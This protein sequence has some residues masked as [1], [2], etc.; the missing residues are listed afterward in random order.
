MSERLTPEEVARLDPFGVRKISA[1]EKLKELLIES[2]T[3]EPEIII[4]EKNEWRRVLGISIEVQP[5]PPFVTKEV[6]RNLK[7]FGLELRFIP[8]L[9]LNPL[10]LKKKGVS[11]FLQELTRRYPNWRPYESLGDKEKSD[12]TVV[13]NLR[14]WHWEAMGNG[15]MDFPNLPGFWVAVE[16]LEKPAS[17]KKYPH[18]LLTDRLGFSDRFNVS[19]KDVTE[20]IDRK[21]QSILAE[22]GL[23]NRADIRL[24]EVLEWNLLANREGWGENTNNNEWINTRYHESDGFSHLGLDGF[25]DGGAEDF[26]TDIPTGFRVAVVVPTLKK[27]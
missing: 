17:G 23:S 20:A 22:I 8:A 21:K 16:T 12:Y 24:L 7:R 25:A 26:R 3:S 13:R 6:M 1:T 2:K 14:E 11:E 27:C 9:E 19:C 15:K 5:L 10:T 4:Q 18:S